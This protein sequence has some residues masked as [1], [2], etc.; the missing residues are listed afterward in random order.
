MP[1]KKTSGKKVPLTIGKE[2]ARRQEDEKEIL[3]ARIGASSLIC[4]DVAELEGRLAGLTPPSSESS[5]SGSTPSVNDLLPVPELDWEF[6]SFLLI[7]SNWPRNLPAPYLLEHLLQVFF[8][9]VPQIP[10][11]FNRPKLMARTK[12]PPNHPDFPHSSLLHAICATAAQYTAMVNNLPAHAI[13]EAVQEKHNRGESLESIQDFSISQAESAHRTIHQTHQLC[14]FGSPAHIFEIFQ[15]EVLISNVWSS[16]G[17]FLR[18]W[19]EGG[20]IARIGRALELANRNHPTRYKARILPAPAD[21]IEREERLA[22]IWYAF[23]SEAFTAVSRYWPISID[24]REFFCALPTS[25]V[26]IARGGRIVENPQTAR[27]PDL[28]FE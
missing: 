9:S 8:T 14:T 13:T 17:M 12:L 6:S 26:D 7:P 16:R 22:S 4:A 1:V 21:D 23:M 3:L 19:S 25:S 27:S 5:G 15:A 10:R 11:I 24:D 28:Y 18:G 2:K 20:Q